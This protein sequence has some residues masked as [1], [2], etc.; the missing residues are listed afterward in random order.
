MI[1]LDVT[2]WNC[3]NVHY[4]LSPICFLENL[5]IFKIRKGDCILCA[6]IPDMNNNWEILPAS[7]E[8]L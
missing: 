6:E 8:V 5:K 7:V 2:Q 4:L 1:L 3:F